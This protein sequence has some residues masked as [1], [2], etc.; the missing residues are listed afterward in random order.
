MKK[1]LALLTAVVLAA[2]CTSESK[3]QTSSASTSSSS[4]TL[5]VAGRSELTLAGDA[6]LAGPLVHPEVPCSF[7]D[8]DGLRITVL[9]TRP[10][11]PFVVVNIGPTSVKVTVNARESESSFT[12]SGVSAF[13]ATKGATVDASLTGTSSALTSITGSV[14][15]GG[16]TP[17]SSTMTVTG[18]A[19]A[20]HLDHAALDPVLVE[21]YFSAG[22][23][24]V[25]GIADT[26]A[27]KAHLVIAITAQGLGV[28]EELQ[29]SGQ[30]RY[31]AAP[32]A[33]SDAAVITATGATA[34]GDVVDDS[35]AP[36]H[37]LH[38]EGTATCGTPV[39]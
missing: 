37:T 13:D 34:N 9:D 39:S 14:E 8:V 6:A 27:G 31:V 20:G 2:A 23:V 5:A 35:V 22:Q 25:L 36:P 18:D 12:G 17:G 33:A 11:S 26:G 3:P 24:I 38:I 4:G 7:P 10:D 30:R 29:P 15:C 28:E 21:C 32:G 1:T 19:A 16:Q